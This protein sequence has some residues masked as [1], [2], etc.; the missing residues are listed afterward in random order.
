MSLS[1]W[2]SPGDPP[3][4]PSPILSAITQRPSPERSA[5]LVH[6]CP[7]PC[8]SP[9]FL[10]IAPKLPMHF[11]GN[12]KE[13]ALQPHIPPPFLPFSPWQ[14]AVRLKHPPFSK[15]PSI[16]LEWKSLCPS[17]LAPHP[18]PSSPDSVCSPPSL[19]PSHSP[20]SCAM[21]ANSLHPQHFFTRS[22]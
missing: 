16:N 21:V 9:A 13:K 12:Y 10:S 3:T 17:I 18:L 15:E 1:V 6:T 11:P 14:N 22:S 19:L 5:Q 8:V 20:N 7:H 2:R 4:H